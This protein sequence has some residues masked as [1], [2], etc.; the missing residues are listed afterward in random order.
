MNGL[1]FKQVSSKNGNFF[2]LEAE[3]IGPVEVAPTVRRARSE[4]ITIMSCRLY[5][6]RKGSLSRLNN[7]EPV[8]KL[9]GIGRQYAQRLHDQGIRT[10]GDLAG[11]SL[12]ERD[13]TYRQQ[14]LDTIRRE[15][16]TMTEAKL[17]EY[18][19]TA[20]SIVNGTGVAVFTGKR[21]Y[22]GDSEEFDGEYDMEAYKRQKTLH[23]P[24][25]APPTGEKKIAIFD[26]CND[27]YFVYCLLL[28]FFSFCFFFFLSN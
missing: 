10:I 7:M 16:G 25:E 15:K 17:V 6:C 11:L 3:L 19:R 5:T 4:N 21:S 14:L 1:R 28:F 18:I 8:S 22:D 2:Q 26:H 27:T 24:V 12:D 20:K 23:S 13:R 9:P